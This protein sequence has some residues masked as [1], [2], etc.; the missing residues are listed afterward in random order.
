MLIKESKMVEHS[1]KIRGCAFDRKSGLMNNDML[2]ISLLLNVQQS[3]WRIKDKWNNYGR[4]APLL[5]VALNNSQNISLN[6]VSGK[7]VWESVTKFLEF[8][9]FEMIKIIE[10]YSTYKYLFHEHKI[11]I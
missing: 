10:L 2:D 7:K 1:S 9:L 6:N 8:K 5:P 3:K 11:T 4:V